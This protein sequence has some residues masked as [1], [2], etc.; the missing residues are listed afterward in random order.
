MEHSYF[1]TKGLWQRYVYKGQ[2]Y[3]ALNEW[4]NDT[5]YLCVYTHARFALKTQIVYFDLITW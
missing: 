1:N 5:M 3:V 4:M 2:L